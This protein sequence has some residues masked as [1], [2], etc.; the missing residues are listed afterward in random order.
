MI[1]RQGR[2]T[3]I[4]I[5]LNDLSFRADMIVMIHRQV[6][7]KVNVLS[8][9]NVLTSS[10]PFS[11]DFPNISVQT[12]IIEV[13]N[14]YVN[15][16]TFATE[17]LQHLYPLIMDLNA[18]DSRDFP[19]LH[20]WQAVEMAKRLDCLCAGITVPSLDNLQVAVLL[21]CAHLSGWSAEKLSNKI[22]QFFPQET[23]VMPETIYS[24]YHNWL[25]AQSQTNSEEDRQNTRDDMLN[26]LNHFSI[27]LNFNRNMSDS[28]RPVGSLIHLMFMHL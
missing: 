7:C 1:H 28:S 25:Y 3:S 21:S 24:A 9:I 12:S 11:Y 20:V 5:Y 6:L 19:S 23:R 17:V 10:H 4:P 13:S 15:Q 16:H 2:I 14:Y 22:Q 18:G 27:E 8:P 26:L